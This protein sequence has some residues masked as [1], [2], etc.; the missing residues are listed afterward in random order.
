MIGVDIQMLDDEGVPVPKDGVTIGEV[1]ARSNVVLKGYWRAAG[2]DRRA[3]STAATS[4]R[5][6]L[7][8]WDEFGNI[9]IVD[10]KKDVIISG[11]ENISSPEIEDALYKHPA[12]LE[13]AVI[14]VPSEQWGET[15]KA[16]IVLRDGMTATEQEI[17]EFSREPPCALQVPDLG[18]LRGGTAAHGDRQAAEVRDPR[19]VLGRRPARQ[20]TRRRTKRRS[21]VDG[22]CV[23]RCL[24]AA[25]RRAELHKHLGRRWLREPRQQRRE[26]VQRVR[27]F[28]FACA[29]N[30]RA[31]HPAGGLPEKPA[32]MAS[33]SSSASRNASVM[34]R[35]VMK[36]R[37]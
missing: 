36:S 19:A 25:H 2:G 1:C 33:L 21:P 14:G 31:R 5:G 7:G 13:C 12:V 30:R 17:I 15:P 6:D 37:W 18:G 16:L 22:A 9:H 3:R 28:R 11:G 29:R 35:P 8:V 26:L 24:R 32:S 10:R 23:S 34:P 4:T 27:R 20:L